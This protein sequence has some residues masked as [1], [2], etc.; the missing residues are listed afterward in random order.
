MHTNLKTAI[1]NG[2]YQIAFHGTATRTRAFTNERIGFGADANSALGLFLTE[3]PESAVEYAD[4]A[5]ASSEGHEPIIYAVAYPARKTYRFASHEAFY[6]LDGETTD[7]TVFRHQLINQGFDSAEFES[8]EDVIRICLNP[9]QALIIAEIGSEQALTLEQ[10]KFDSPMI[11]ELLARHGWLDL[12]QDPMPS[13]APFASATLSDSLAMINR[14]L[15]Q[16]DGFPLECDGMT[17]A[18]S[19]LLHANHIE[20][21]VHAGRICSTSEE[22]NGINHYWIQFEDGFII[23]L[24]AR[25]WM[26]QQAPHGYFLNGNVDVSYKSSGTVDNFTL[27]PILF[28]ILTERSIDAIT[29][30]PAHALN[31]KP[32][33]HPLLANTVVS[34][35][36]GNPLRVF[37]GE[38]GPVDRD[39]ALLSTHLPS[40]TFSSSSVANTYAMTPNVKSS[41]NEHLS[42]PRIVPC[43]L[44]ITN[45]VFSSKRDPYVDYTD[46]V[47]LMGTTEATKAFL[48][49]SR[50][51]EDTN[52]FHELSVEHGVDTLSD[53][54]RC[55]P[56]SLTELYGLAWELLDDPEFVSWC[57]SKGYDG[58]I[59]LG[60]GASLDTLEYRVFDTKQVVS[61]ITLESDADRPLEYGTPSTVIKREEGSIHSRHATSPSP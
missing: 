15:E 8:G 26:G 30:F 1:A 49:I 35:S 61:A 3:L 33:K 16:F 45:P 52:A 25:M 43:Y 53:L 23:D 11:L 48:R 21:E 14:W 55:A 29:P 17:R 12:I 59:N 57:I 22:Q 13:P 6:G 5:V 44:S 51:V 42:Q 7:F 47:S 9:D 46:L 24:R 58:A 27:D 40:I 38:H 50:S 56:E 36:L 37:R 4:M 31:R 32:V 18:I 10:A 39:T 34:D 28:E 60:S 20:H 54:I 41:W 2:D 19:T